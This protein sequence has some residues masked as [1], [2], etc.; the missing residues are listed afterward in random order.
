LV[1]EVRVAVV[2]AVEISRLVVVLRVE[3]DAAAHLES[4]PEKFLRQVNGSQ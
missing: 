3:M 2:G 1:K 4:A